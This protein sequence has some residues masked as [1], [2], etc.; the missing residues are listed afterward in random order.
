MIMRPVS[1]V[2]GFLGSGKTTLI[3]R[4]LRDPGFAR[5]AVIVNE[6]GE[7][8]LDHELIASSDETLLALT[9]GC[10]CCA[11]R[12]D[13]VATLLE[14]RGRAEAGEIAFDRALVETSGLAD[15][16]PILHAL[17]TD[18]DV[19]AGYRLDSV[20]T[21]VDAVLGEAT[22]DRHPEARRQAALADRLALSKTDL[23]GAAESLRAR[24]AGLNPAAPLAATGDLVPGWLF[25][26][27][28]A[29]ARAE[30]LAGLP[31]EVGRSPFRVGTRGAVSQAV[32][33][34]GV[35]T[36]ALQRQRP[37]PALA[38]ALMLQALAEHCGARLL[39]LKG[40]VNVAEMPGQPAVIHGVQHVFAPPDFLPRW[41]S[42]DRS[43]RL[44]FIA[45]RVPR[46]FPARLLDAIE[47]EVVEEMRGDGD[48]LPTQG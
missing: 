10:L 21:V 47:A 15:P 13:L 42:A 22:L 18:A 11:V 29:E 3:G 1:V 38:L 20:L 16:A 32:H 41:P 8:G 33:S 5:T 27:G 26:G 31:F 19:A 36:F 2:T 28:D 46:H 9:T 25:G 23:A 4:V 17:M 7:I 6:F 37:V 45:Q 39:R 43:T 48:P 30:R 24:L 35:T 40:L 34:D 44:V 12:S 14:L